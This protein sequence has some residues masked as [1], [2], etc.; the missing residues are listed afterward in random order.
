MRALDLAEND[1]VKI[2]FVD[3]NNARLISYGTA[4]D[5]EIGLE[6]ASATQLQL[7]GNNGIQLSAN[8]THTFVPAW[9]NL[10]GN[11]LTILVD[12]GNNGTIDDTLHIENQITDIEDDHSLMLIPDEYR[13]DQNYPNPFNNS[14]VIKYAIPQEGLVTLKIYNAIGEEVATLLNETKQAGNYTATFDATNLTSG[15]YLYRLQSGE[16]IETKKMI[17]LK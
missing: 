7:F 6:Y 11:L 9:P 10:Y 14:T 4:K 8:T 16:F 2:E 13:L 5:Y 3:N 12:V 1:S 15:I 17:L